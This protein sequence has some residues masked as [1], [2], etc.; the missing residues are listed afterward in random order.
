MP[1]FLKLL[2]VTFVAFLSLSVLGIVGFLGLYLYLAPGLPRAETLRDVE[3]QVPL[4]IYAADGRLMAEYG[5]KRR[6]PLRYD[7]IPERIKLAFLAAEDDRFFKHPGVDYRG[8][9]RAA[10]HLALTGEK[11]QG[12][13]TI[14]M[15]LARNFFLS[16]ERTYERKLREIF[17][18]LQIEHALSKPQILELY[19][20][21]IYLGQRA[22]GVGAAAE[23][24]YGKSPAELSLAQIAM[25]AGL[26][27]APSAYNPIS[28][29]RR[30]LVRRAYVLR[31]MRDLGYITEEEYVQAN[32]APV[33]ASVH[34]AQVE[35]DAPYLAEA[36]RVRLL[37]R[38]GP[39]AYS[40]GYEVYTTL[41][42]A[43]QSAGQAALRKAL[44][45][46][47][48]RHGW[49]GAAGRVAL[50]GRTDTELMG[51]LARRTKVGGLFPA[52]VKAVG[53]QSA[54]V[55]IK[56]V[57]QAEV[58]WAGLSWARTYIDEDRRGPRPKKASDVLKPGDLIYVQRR[59]PVAPRVNGAE[60][61]K[62]AAAYWAL[63]QVPEVQG[64]LISVNPRDGAVLALVGGFDFGRSKFNRA[65]QARRQPGS[66]FKPFVYSA[67]LEKGFTPASIINDAPI[68]FE[69]A[70]SEAAWRPQNY[71]GKFFG[72]TRL[73]VALM[74]S[75]NLV[76]IRLLQRIGIDYTL[77]YVKRFGFDTS[78]FP[79]NL[80]LALGTGE[81]TP[82]ELIGGFAVFANGGYRV[83]PF[84][85]QRIERR[86]RV[87]E[88][89]E[90]LPAC[91]STAEEPAA[92]DCAPRAITPQNAYQMVSM[93][94]D[95]IRHGTGRKALALK[96]GDLAGKTGTTNEQRDAWFS[97]FNA[98]LVATVWVGFDDHGR[99]GKRETGAGAALP[100]WI[101]YMRKALAGKPEHTLPR[102]PGLATVRI[103]PRTGLL[104]A[105]G[106]S[107]A[108][109]ETFRVQ[110]VPTA[111]GTSDLSPLYPADVDRGAVPSA[112]GA[113]T[114]GDVEP[115]F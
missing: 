91:D 3:L 102:P 6:K 30:A 41:D 101:E 10:V 108:I 90:P 17:L 73:R 20:N 9:L 88:M 56:G 26:P 35:V 24:Y 92:P 22:Y 45:D 111:Y 79:R 115:L 42:P 105:P 75:R 77:D 76:S 87:V 53:K 63:V 82:A 78:R 33:T 97:G 23:V 67:A 66:N 93:M 104:A 59:R 47:D 83:A 36:V 8:L 54:T 110:Y 27:K 18:A 55:L 107:D 70:S 98:D 72:P 44:L 12:G 84:W 46:Y 81:V 14:T 31:R 58:P 40:A 80:S 28:N 71:S 7:Q 57:G 85:I 68:V 52:V 16:S 11:Q 5:E 25:I 109:F 69:D 62:P 96:R 15:Q 48:R 64:A 106:Q 39:E 34:R 86:G 2:K 32:E 100:M 1:L 65:L 74:K 114:G 43:L 61:G 49:R 113:S 51:L 95:V 13:S 103:D 94:Q 21:K 89:H 99:L 19:L 60:A 50:E 37:S 38:F 112:G 29:P 4:R